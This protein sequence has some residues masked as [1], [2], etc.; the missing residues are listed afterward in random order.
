MKFT[1]C[2]PP[3]FNK[4]LGVDEIDTMVEEY[5]EYGYDA[6]DYA[7]DEVICDIAR[8]DTGVKVKC[9]DPSEKCNILAYLVPSVPP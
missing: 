5:Y 1:T 7:N 2:I 4:I 3:G 6:Y 9:S 8:V